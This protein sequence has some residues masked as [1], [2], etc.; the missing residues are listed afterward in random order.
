MLVMIFE[1][2]EK[3]VIENLYIEVGIRT[4]PL[5][6]VHEPNQHRLVPYKPTVLVLLVLPGGHHRLMSISGLGLF[7][8]PQYFPN[9]TRLH[10]YMFT[11]VSP[12]HEIYLQSSGG[13]PTY[14]SQNPGDHEYAVLGARVTTSRRACDSSG[15]RHA[16]L[17]VW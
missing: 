5:N 17:F 10:P 3:L 13:H 14:T 2:V 6:P 11:F 12:D 7:P 4:N 8:F 1:G 9:T 16:E 15:L